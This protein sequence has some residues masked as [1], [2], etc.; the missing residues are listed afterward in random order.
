MIEPLA[1][2]M[3]QMEEG[4]AVFDAQT[5]KEVESPMAIAG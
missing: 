5:Q 3:R 1:R 4:F 2:T